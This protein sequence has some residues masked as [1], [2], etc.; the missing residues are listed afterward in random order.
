MVNI[1][2]SMQE[3]QKMMIRTKKDMKAISV[4]VNS[5]KYFLEHAFIIDY[6]DYYRLLVIHRWK[7]LTDRCYKTLKGARVAF[8][9]MYSSRSWKDE[10]IPEWSHFYNPGIEYLNFKT[11]R[12]ER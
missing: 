9:K 11:A 12:V 2:E 3:R 8:I 4:L 6:D 5:V 1:N 7:L 10:D